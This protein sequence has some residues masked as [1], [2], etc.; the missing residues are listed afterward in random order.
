MPAESFDSNRLLIEIDTKL[1]GLIDRFD[2]VSQG[3][4]FTRCVSREGRIKR[5]E[6]D[7]ISIK[8]E[9]ADSVDVAAALKPLSDEIAVIKK[10]K[11]DFDTWLMRLTWTVIICGVVKIAFASHTGP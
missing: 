4:G 9:K 5:L 2:A 1:K 6:Q 10:R 8:R 7:V 11:S 3:D